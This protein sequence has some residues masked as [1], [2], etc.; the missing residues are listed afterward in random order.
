MSKYSDDLFVSSCEDQSEVALACLEALAAHEVC[1][2]SEAVISS[3]MQGLAEDI[4]EEFL[5]AKR[6]RDAA[7]RA[8]RLCPSQSLQDIYIKARLVSALSSD[9]GHDPRIGV[10]SLEIVRELLRIDLA[11]LF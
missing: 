8:V 2:V 10:M 5:T 7:I 11:N 6:G 1:A 3:S 4:E 9:F